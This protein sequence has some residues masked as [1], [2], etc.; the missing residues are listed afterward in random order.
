M[1]RVNSRTDLNKIFSR[2]W[3]KY[4]WL[5]YDYDGPALSLH[6]FVSQAKELLKNKIKPEAELKKIENNR[7]QLIKEQKQ[8]EKEVKFSTQEK[9]LFWL[10]RQLSFIKNYRKDVLYKSYY[11]NDKLLTEI[12]RRLSLSV[13]QVKH[14]LP[15]E[16]AGFLFTKKDNLVL[17]NQRINYSVL[18][19]TSPK[20]QIFTGKKAKNLIK[21]LVAKEVSQKDIKELK[22]QVAYSGKVLGK[23]RIVNWPAE[24][25]NFKKG[26]ILVSEK[27][28]PNLIPAIKKA[29]AIITDEGGLTC[30]AAI[31]SRELKIPCIVGTK[32]ATQIFKTGDLLEVDANQGVVRKIK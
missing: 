31:I 19:Y 21:R 24:M 5:Q 6:Y 18:T 30:H 22:G 20:L 32:I 26:E 16:M 23:V 11:Q 12:G 27:T 1:T 15:Q 17:L 2:H 25:K 7:L 13:R 28:N 4:C 10:A 8:Y 9:Y 14:I 29:A 3:A